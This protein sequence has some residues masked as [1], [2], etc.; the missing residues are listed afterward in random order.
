MNRIT[1]NLSATL[2]LTVVVLTFVA[3]SGVSVLAQCRQTQARLFDSPESAAKALID[4]ASKND[5]SGLTAILGSAAQ[6]ILTSG[7]ATQDQAERR[8]FSR[9]ASA[10]NR[11]EHSSMNSAS[12]VLLVGNEDWPFPIPLVKTGQQWHFDPES[13][14][15]EMHARR[16][17]GN[18]L[19]AIEICF[20]YVTAQETFARQRLAGTGAP[21]YA[22]TIM[23]APGSKDGLY[24]AGVSPELV[25]EG[26][27][28]ADAG[29]AGGPKKPYHDYYFR[30]LKEQGPAAP[31]GA[32]KYVMGNN[33][34]G[35]FALI[36]WP[37]EYGVTGIRTFIVNHDGQVYEK[38]LGPKTATLSPAI[39]KYDPDSS[40]TLV[41]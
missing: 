1:T 36:A 39:V 27:A 38:D 8:E 19:D 16:I 13:G 22:L 34:I 37:A 30:V 18:E 17:G 21:V 31:G 4:A 11:V 40:W 23:S 14:A 9:L 5:T 29:A 3:I 28:L 32:H 41:D 26:F 20:G 33:M 15:V 10:K 25:P 2:V 12:A 35:G 24:Q 7:N 6:G